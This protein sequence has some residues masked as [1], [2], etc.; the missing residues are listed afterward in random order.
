MSFETVSCGFQRKIGLKQ[1]HFISGASSS[2]GGNKRLEVGRDLGWR[3]LIEPG[4][5]TG[6]LELS[7]L[8]GHINDTAD[9]AVNQE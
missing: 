2:S 4:L 1:T 7:F 6:V 3:K 9:D 8:D 5:V